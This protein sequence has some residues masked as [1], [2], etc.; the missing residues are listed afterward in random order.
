M[1]ALAGGQFL[2]GND[3][4]Y[5]YAED[6]EGPVREVVVEPLEM[7]ETAVTNERFASFVAASGHVTDAERFGWSFVFAGFLPNDAPATRGVAAAPWWRQVYG[8]DWRHPEGPASNLEARGEHPVTHV[9][10]RDA[11]AY[12]AWTGK[13]LPTEAEWEYGARGGLVQKRFPWGDELEPEGQHRM[14]VGQGTFPRRNTMDDGYAGTAPVRSY[15][16][17]GFGLFEMTGNVWEWTTGSYD[18]SGKLL[19]MRGG[20]YLCHASYCNRYRVDARSGSTADS[21]TGNLGF[22]CVRSS[23]A[24]MMEDLQ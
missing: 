22:R 19:T 6:R 23:A 17:N 24:R 9:S 10:W 21:S 11:S 13:R 14:N 5:A 15:P 3:R 20:S 12:A 1:I 7:D 16:P 2:M 18:P 4:D 8:A